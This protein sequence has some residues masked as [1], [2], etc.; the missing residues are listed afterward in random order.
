MYQLRIRRIARQDVQDAVDYYDSFNPKV[1]DRFLDKLYAEF[2]TITSN[3]YLFQVKYRDTR[4]RYLQGFP[5]GI[6]YII[7]GEM[8]EVLA[9]LHT[10]R[11]QQD[12]QRK[13]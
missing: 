12:W 3:P 8:I 6:H 9:V 5:F 13:R 7:D 2:D 10:S 4:V 11:N 1:T